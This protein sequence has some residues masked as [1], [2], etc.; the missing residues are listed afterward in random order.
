MR[1]ETLLWGGDEIIWVVPAWQGWWMVNEFYSQ[2]KEHIKHNNEPLFHAAGL[3]F[4]HHDAP[5]HRIDSL[6]RALADQFAK[7][8]R[9]KNLIAYQILESFDH[10]GTELTS[11]R[12]E[13]MGKLGELEQLLID[14]EK[15]GDIKAYIS[16]LKN[17]PDFAKRKVYQ[18]LEAYSVGET[19]KADQYITK[20]PESSTEPLEKL[21]QIFGGDNVHWLHLMDL[22]D[23]IE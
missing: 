8:D 16:Q 13:C 1:L 18:I 5:I 4:C 19:Q 20:L 10:A 9:K 3:V 11:Y 15:M 6:A 12:M 21:E 23:Y 22:W 2:A 14:A 7:A 17:D